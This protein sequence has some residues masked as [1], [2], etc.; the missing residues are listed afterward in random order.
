MPVGRKPEYPWCCY[1]LGSCRADFR[2][3]NVTD[4]YV[5]DGVLGVIHGISAAVLR[6]G[7]L[8]CDAPRRCT[9]RDAYGLSLVKVRRSPDATVPVCSRLLCFGERVGAAVDLCEK[10]R[11]LRSQ[12]IV[13]T[14]C[15]QTFV[16]IALLKRHRQMCDRVGLFAAISSGLPLDTIVLR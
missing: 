8:S 5:A 10:E 12:R 11:V 15:F 1:R 13:D 6:R 2:P 3:L 9:V 7:T 16:C 4:G 14:C